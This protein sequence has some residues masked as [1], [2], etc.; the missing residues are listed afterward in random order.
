MEKSLAEHRQLASDLSLGSS[1]E[2]IYRTALDLL[3][4]YCGSGSHLDFGCGQGHFLKQL[5]SKFPE[6]KLSGV[7]LMKKPE[8]VSGAVE[9]FAEDLNQ[10]LDLPAQSLDSISA[11]EIIEHLENPRHVFRELYRILKP[12]GTLVLSTPNN[13]TWRAILS[14]IKR[15][16][17][18]AFTDRDY[19]AHI[20]PLNRK[21]LLRIAEE[22]GFSFQ[23]WGFS[24]KGCLP[25]MTR[26]S[27]QGLS[28][29]MLK[30]LRYSDNIFMVLKK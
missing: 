16:H 24:G 13:E 3:Q 1:N 7:D 27:W 30:G 2:L 10:N 26:F 4:E 28:L 15:G 9:W 21:D 6:L 12:G 8:K 22:S 5:E 29:G 25:G 17:F 20:T 14:Y 18:V 11:L 23:A 19:P